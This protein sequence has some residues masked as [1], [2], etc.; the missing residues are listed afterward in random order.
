MNKAKGEIRKISE[1]PYYKDEFADQLKEMDIESLSD[2][3]DA[4]YDDVK[5]K[6]IID[7]L[8]G[9]GPKIADHWIEIIE[10]R[11][12]LEDVTEAEEA[13]TEGK[14]RKIPMPEKTTSEEE[15]KKEAPKEETVIEEGPPEVETKEGEII[16]KGGYIAKLKPVLDANTRELLSKRNTMSRKRPHFLRQEGFRFKRLGDTWR[17]PRG[18]HSKM[19]R[20]YKYRPPVVSIGYRG[21]KKVRGLHSSG[22]EEVMVHTPAKLDGIDSKRQAVRIGGSVG[23]KKRLEIEARADKLGIR[24]L[25]RTG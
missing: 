16:E 3:L 25:N 12:D 17:R 4:L 22:F 19:R 24:V 18:M 5:K 8:K 15:E 1:L 2:L 7:E 21:P 23:Y 11:G 9:V 6:R 14:A 20:H 10:E 13:P